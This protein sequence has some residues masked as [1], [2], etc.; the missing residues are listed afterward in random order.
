MSCSEANQG[1]AFASSEHGW[2]SGHERLR[3]PIGQIDARGLP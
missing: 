3:Q 1:R 2:L